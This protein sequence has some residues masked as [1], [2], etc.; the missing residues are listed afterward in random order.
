M[1]GL[2]LTLLA[3]AAALASVIGFAVLLVIGALLA[4]ALLPRGSPLADRLR[5]FAGAVPRSMWRAVLWV[6][7]FVFVAAVAIAVVLTFA[8]S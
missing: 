7:G 2:L 1:S 6:D 5:H 8:L 4:A 3:F